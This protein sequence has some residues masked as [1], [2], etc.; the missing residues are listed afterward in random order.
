M[1]IPKKLH[2][3][4]I[5]IGI[6]VAYVA[7]DLMLACMMKRRSPSAFE[8]MIKAVSGGEGLMIVVLGLL[9]G[10]AAWYFSSRSKEYFRFSKKKQE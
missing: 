9:I 10:L 4:D 3:K 6:L 7:I 2:W 5:V 8:R 1:D